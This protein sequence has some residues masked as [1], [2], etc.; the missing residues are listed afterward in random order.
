MPTKEQPDGFLPA[1]NCKQQAFAAPEYLLT[2]HVAG[3]K[4]LTPLYQQHL[5]PKGPCNLVDSKFLVTTLPSAVIAFL[6]AWVWWTR[7]GAWRI[8]WCRLG[9]PPAP[10]GPAWSS[11][12]RRQ[13]PNHRQNCPPAEAGQASHAIVFHL[14]RCCEAQRTRRPAQRPKP[15]CLCCPR[16][17]SPTLHKGPDPPRPKGGK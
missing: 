16:S 4:E 5:S 14:R 10:S 7:T 17:T 9:R 8:I 15:C 6:T 11:L 12:F 13:T 2:S 3:I 1:S